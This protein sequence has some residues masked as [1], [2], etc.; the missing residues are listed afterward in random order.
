MAGRAFKQSVTQGTGDIGKVRLRFGAIDA[1]IK[2]VLSLMTTFTVSN[3]KAFQSQ[4]LELAPLTMLTGLNGS[5]ESSLMHALL[6]LRQAYESGFL[7][8]G[9]VP[10]NGDHVRLGTPVDVSKESSSEDGVK[11]ALTLSGYPTLNRSLSFAGESDRVA[12]ATFNEFP[13]EDDGLFGKDFIFL[14]ADRLSPQ[15]YYDVPNGLSANG[16]IGIHGE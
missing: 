2:K 1:L 4:T 3:F 16:R 12:L 14:A 13:E 8:R 6:L 11:F 9:T 15:A 5:G 7:Y 10:L